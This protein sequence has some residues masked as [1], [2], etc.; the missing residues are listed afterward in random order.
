MVRISGI[1]LPQ[2]KS[3]VIGLTYIFGIGFSTSKIIVSQTKVDPQTKIMNL[4]NM[5][6]IRLRKIFE[7]QYQ[8]ESSLKRTFASN[9]KKNIDI[10]SYIGRRH[11]LG[12]PA[13]GQR[14][15]TNARTRRARVSNAIVK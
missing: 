8:T 2:K 5:A 12:L 7:N 13:H 11:L 15:K 3:I 10:N 1:D 9:I 6:I 4:T 14:T